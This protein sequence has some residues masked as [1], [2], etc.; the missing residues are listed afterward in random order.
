MRDSS[1]VYS[2]NSYD[3]IPEKQFKNFRST[4]TKG[5]KICNIFYSI[6]YYVYNPQH[7]FKLQE[8]N[9]IVWQSRICVCI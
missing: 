6:L 2:Y 4:W 9:V 1:L 5:S 3:T 7:E 8:Y